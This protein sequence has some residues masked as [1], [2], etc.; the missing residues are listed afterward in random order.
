MLNRGLWQLGLCAIAGIA[1]A[2]VDAV[3]GAKFRN[4]NK[5]FHLKCLNL[6]VRKTQIV[7][8]QARDFLFIHLSCSFARNV[9]FVF[10]VNGHWCSTR[11]SLCNATWDGLMSIEWSTTIV[12]P[13]KV[14]AWNF[15]YPNGSLV[16]PT[17]GSTENYTYELSWGASEVFFA[18]YFGPLAN[19]S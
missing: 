17:I 8:S 4:A 15:M 12:N 5:L 16:V 14:T 10:A 2:I 13:K 1:A 19:N 6:D 3:R 9:F 18:L 7:Q 11:Q